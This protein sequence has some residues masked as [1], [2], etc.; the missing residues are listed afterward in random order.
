[1]FELRDET[2]TLIE[3]ARQKGYLKTASEADVTLQASAS[4][5]PL[6]KVFDEHCESLS[7]SK[8]G[9]T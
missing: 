9:S 1:M 4:A 2:L 3:Q 8:R 6:S 5:G 7:T